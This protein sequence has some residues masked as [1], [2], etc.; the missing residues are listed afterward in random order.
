MRLQCLFPSLRVRS[1]LTRSLYHTQ[2]A[3][4]IANF[5]WSDAH[6]PDRYVFNPLAYW[7]FTNW[8]PQ[9]GWVLALL[10]LCRTS[11]SSKKNQTSGS[12]SACATEQYRLKDPLLEVSDADMPRQSS[13]DLSALDGVFDDS[14]L[15]T[16]VEDLMS[17]NSRMY[18]RDLNTSD[19]TDC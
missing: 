8:V 3:L 15:M 18:S 13:D 2:S 12:A 6:D 4:L 11:Q 19:I 7:I 16:D 1:W 9:V 5:I 14:V 10:Y 17:E